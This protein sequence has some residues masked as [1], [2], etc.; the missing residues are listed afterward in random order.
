MSQRWPP[1]PAGSPPLWAHHP[2]RA[3]DRFGWHSRPEPKSRRLRPEIPDQEARRKRRCSKS[4]QA[5][6]GSVRSRP[7]LGCQRPDARYSDLATT[8][9]FALAAR[10]K[11]S[12]YP[13]V[14]QSLADLTCWRSGR[15]NS[16]F[17]R[18]DFVGESTRFQGVQL[19]DGLIALALQSRKLVFII[20][21]VG[22]RD[23]IPLRHIT[24]G[25][26]RQINHL[27]G[28]FERQFDLA[29]A[30]HR[31]WIPP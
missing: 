30:E 13:G 11:S 3:R 14:V 16:C 12:R 24:C 22:L 20:T 27:A 29:R 25:A 26:H 15:F 9:C 6:C 10:S 23:N 21:L 8:R 19:C 5:R 2:P 18:D 1:C 17:Q 4:V 7:G 31:G 28:H